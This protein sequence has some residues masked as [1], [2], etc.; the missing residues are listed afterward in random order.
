MPLCSRWKLKSQVREVTATGEKFD[1]MGGHPKG[2]L[3]YSADGRMYAIVT[4][5]NRIKPRD[6]NPTDEE[7]VKLHCPSSN[8]LRELGLS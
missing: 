1:Q 5:D 4:S 2:Y 3:S 6:A 8:A 7:R